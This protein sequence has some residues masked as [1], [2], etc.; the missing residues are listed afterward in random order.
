V[1]I[2]IIMP[3]PVEERLIASTLAATL[4]WHRRCPVSA[5]RAIQAEACENSFAQ[6]S[7]LR[8]LLRRYSKGVE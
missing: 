8:Q 6:M 1:D 7:I 4:A 2:S 5:L 3:E